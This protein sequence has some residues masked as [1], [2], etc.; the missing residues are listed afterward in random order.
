MKH[1]LHIQCHKRLLV[2]LKSHLKNGSERKE[3]VTEPE[4]LYSQNQEMTTLSYAFALLPLCEAWQ[5]Q[6]LN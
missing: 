4:V 5:P 3:F 6:W 2:L 1:S